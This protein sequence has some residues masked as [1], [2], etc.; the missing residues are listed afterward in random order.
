MAANADA[1]AAL[2]EHV[3]D[4]F[5]E[6]AMHRGDLSNRRQAEAD[7]ERQVAAAERRNAEKLRSGSTDLERLP[8][9]PLPE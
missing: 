1:L 9:R 3:A 5:E 4:L 6:S 2:S 8:K 7:W